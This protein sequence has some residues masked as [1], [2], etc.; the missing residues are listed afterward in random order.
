MKPPPIL[1]RVLRGGRVE[2]VHRGHVAVVAEGGRVM[3]AAGEAGKAIYLR[4][5]AKPF[6]AMLLLETGGERAFRL[7][8]GE[9][10]LMCSSHGGEPGHVSAAA[11]LLAKGGFTARDLFCG[12]HMPMH[13]PSARALL[14]RGE[15]P[16]PLHNNCSGKHAGLLLATR[17]LGFSPKGY[18]EPSHPI[19]REV[20]ARLSTWT[21][22][23]AGRI[24]IAVDGCSLPVFHLPLAALARGYARLVSRE[25]GPFAARIVQAMWERPEM[26]AGRQRFTTDFLQAGRGRWVGKEGA[27]GVYA[28]GIR[29]FRAGE[30]SLGLAFKIEDGGVRARDTVSLA[31]LARLGRLPPSAARA[32]SAYRR[33][34]VLNARGLVV[35][36]IDPEASHALADAA[37]VLGRRR[38]RNAKISRFRARGA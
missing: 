3:A 13:E 28:I 29:A 23:P 31:L 6:Q 1:A 35:G 14:R 37:G 25:A 34:P 36:R 15:K 19:Q 8:S 10:A 11:R 24:R 26:M 21:G 30:E 17:L 7:T 27:E 20:K 32:L 22:V 4:S 9:I 33:P 12:A 2:S 5:A 38:S 18:W 16:S